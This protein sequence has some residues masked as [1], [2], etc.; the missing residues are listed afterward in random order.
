[1]DG[2]AEQGGS[3]TFSV[4]K[5]SGCVGPLGVQPTPLRPMYELASRLV[6]ADSVWTKPECRER[7]W[8]Q[9][10]DNSHMH[11]WVSGRNTARACGRSM[12]SKVSAVSSFV[13][14]G[15]Q[16]LHHVSA[17]PPLIPDGRISRVRL[18]ASDVGWYRNAA[19]PEPAEA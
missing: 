8:G 19:F 12:A 17:S 11:Q 5:G 10:G 7:P 2:T 14:K 9:V 18:A 13:A 1:M 3:L 6:E 4:G 16:T 15:H